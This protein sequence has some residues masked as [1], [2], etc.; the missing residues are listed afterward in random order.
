MQ[1]NIFVFGS[2][3][4]GRHGAG[5]ARRARLA[6]GAK[7]GQGKGLQ[8][9]SYAI[10]TKDS[11]LKT[12]PIGKISS[13][14]KEFKEFVALN[15]DKEFYVTAIGTGLAGLSHEQIA[16]LFEN[17]PLNCVFPKTWETYLGAKYR[18]FTENL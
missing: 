4:A 8:G 1:N 13:Y 10:P 11:S 7:Y 12:L 3:T 5:A 18:Y 2:N 15:P 16:P 17:S 14:I 6:Y 9:R